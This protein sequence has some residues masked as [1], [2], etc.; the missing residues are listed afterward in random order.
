LIVRDTV[1]SDLTGPNT[2]GS[3]PQHRDV[4]QAILAQSERDYQIGDDFGRVV[5][6]QRLAPRR[7]RPR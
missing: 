5:H 4:G 2:P 6:G 7:Q 1:G 3:A